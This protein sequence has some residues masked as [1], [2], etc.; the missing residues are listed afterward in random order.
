V[1]RSS[2][3]LSPALCLAELVERLERIAGTL[4]IES[5]DLLACAYSALCSGV[6][7]SEDVAGLAVF[8]WL[9]ISKVTIRELRRLA[10]TT[11]LA[12]QANICQ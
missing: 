10:T 2:Y 4:A 7:G 12:W 11:I 6:G 9:V 8:A 3:I 1:N 5:D